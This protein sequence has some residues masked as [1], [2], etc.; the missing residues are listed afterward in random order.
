MQKTDP[1]A[2]H[3]NGLVH[4]MDPSCVPVMMDA[5]PTSGFR[6]P[7]R[8]SSE[9]QWKASKASF[10]PF[11]P[12]M[13]H[14]GCVT[15]LGPMVALVS[16]SWRSCHIPEWKIPRQRTTDL[17][18]AGAPTANRIIQQSQKENKRYMIAA[19][20]LANPGID[21]LGGQCELLMIR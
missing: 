14:C 11:C 3:T 19:D 20:Y 2:T 1:T 6:R 5:K 8:K 9:G 4:R 16:P 13:C 15:H 7:S 21:F 10:P 12:P 18:I 17:D